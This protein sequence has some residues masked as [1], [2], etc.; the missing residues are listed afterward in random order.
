[1]DLWLSNGRFVFDALDAGTTTADYASL[2]PEPVQVFRLWQIYIDNVD[3]LLKVTHI[4]TLQ[5]RIIEAMGDAKRSTPTLEAL[6]CGIYCMA[7]N[8]LRDAECRETFGAPKKQLMHKFRCLCQQALCQAEYLRTTDRDCLTAWYFYLV[9]V[10]LYHNVSGVT[11]DLRE[12]TQLSIGHTTDTR[13]LS[14]MLAV[15]MRIARRMGL[16]AEA[17]LAKCSVLEAEMRRRLWWSLSMFETRIAEMA[18]HKITGLSTDWDCRLPLNVNDADLRPEMKEPPRAGV[19]Q[20]NKTSEAFF[21]LVRCELASFF[22]NCHHLRLDIDRDLDRDATRAFTR[23]FQ[24]SL[25]A[26]EKL[27]DD[28]YLRHCD[29][30]N[31]L[32]TMAICATRSHIA[33]CRLMERYMASASSVGSIAE[34]ERDASITQTFIILECD[35]TMMTNP[36]LVRFRWL[37]DIYFPLPAYIHLLLDV[38]RRPTSPHAERAWE[39]MSANYEARFTATENPVESPMFKFFTGIILGAWE[40]VAAAEENNDVVP[41]KIITDIRSQ[42]ER[43][44]LGTASPFPSEQF[45]PGMSD[46]TGVMPIGFDDN[47]HAPWAWP[48]DWRGMVSGLSIYPSDIEMASSGV[49]QF[50]WAPEGYGWGAQQNTTYN[51][52]PAM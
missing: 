33:R 6:M 22:R 12:N 18:E 40:P 23:Q 13:T 45:D 16:H 48:P 4:P 47:V 11:L 32:H 44:S 41:P 8:S 31:P 52:D 35:T 21:S 14:S 38:K 2:R 17:E 37:L 51:F 46:F 36:L 27:V 28:R 7:V 29:P 43:M 20:L 25:A 42:L 50:P 1:M 9:C 10:D 24:A 39:I 3:P 5:P 30:E 15:A 49:N 19:A 34:A 26:L